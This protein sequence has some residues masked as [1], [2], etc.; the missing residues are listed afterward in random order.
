[1]CKRRDCLN[2]YCTKYYTSHK[3]GTWLTDFFWH[4][5]P[6]LFTPIVVVV[7]RQCTIIYY[8]V[9]L[10]PPQAPCC[11]AWALSMTGSWICM[12][13]QR[14][15]NR[16]MFDFGRVDARWRAQWESSHWKQCV[17]LNLRWLTRVDARHTR[18][19]RKHL[20]KRK[21]PEKS[22]NWKMSGKSHWC[23]SEKCNP[24]ASHNYSSINPSW[25]ISSVVFFET[26]TITLYVVLCPG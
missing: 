3:Y 12:T 18:A 21:N 22:R 5:F 14:V 23:M 11:Y 19:V 24:D 15:V 20:N 13:R 17:P 10:R 8:D 1:M 4:N 26:E 7:G 25:T 2:N 16:D 6:R 9:L